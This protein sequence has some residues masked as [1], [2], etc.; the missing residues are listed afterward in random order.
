MI[1]ILRHYVL[2]VDQRARL[3]RISRDWLLGRTWLGILGLQKPQAQDGMM[4]DVLH[5]TEGAGA[6]IRCSAEVGS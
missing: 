3:A 1:L 6:L 4:S 5:D 2:A